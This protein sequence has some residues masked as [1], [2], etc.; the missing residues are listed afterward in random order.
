ML[1]LELTS[2]ANSLLIEFEASEP[3]LAG[4]RL[5]SKTE[6]DLDV[7][8]HAIAAGGKGINTAAGNTHSH[9]A[10]ARQALPQISSRSFFRA[11]D[12]IALALGKYASSNANN[13]AIAD[14]LHERLE[15]FSKNF[16]AYLSDQ[17]GVRALP[18]LRSATPLLIELET[19]RR[20]LTSTVAQLTN[21][22]SL[23]EDEEVFSIFFPDDQSLDEIAA[24]LKALQAIFDLVGSLIESPIVETARV[25][26]LEYGSFLAELAVSRSILKVARPWIS[27]LAGF[28]YRTRTL[29]GSLD[30]TT[31]ASKAAIKLA[32]D[33][34][35]LLQKAGISTQ[36]MDAELEEAGTAMA[37]NV[38]A[39]IGNQIR[40]KVDGAE[41]HA[42][43]ADLQLENRIAQQLP[44]P[45]TK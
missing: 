19:L 37:K 22:A 44:P 40:F 5:L 32:L 6:R 20:T 23:Q 18:V 30:S 39:L 14:S 33:V 4:L 9:F 10:S 7:H 21:H 1:S 12:R 11:L 41:F 36:K 13:A 27:G 28:F 29:E 17:S 42:T 38:A 26:R 31:T 16:E 34:R 2:N 35:Q 25:L 45:D 3:L 24:K 8:L 15:E 43:R